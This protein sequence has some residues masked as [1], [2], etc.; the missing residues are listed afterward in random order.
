MKPNIRQAIPTYVINLEHRTDRKT[1]II[2]EFANREEFNIT[3]V[4]AI[5]HPIGAIGLWQTMCHII[6]KAKEGKV[7]FVLICEDDHHFTDNYSPE[8]LNVAIQ[9]AQKHL[10]D[11]LLGGISWFDIVLQVSPNLFWVN[12]FNATQF[13][14]VFDSCY[15]QIL[16]TRFDDGENADFK[17][18]SLTD[19]ILVMY[20]FISIQKEFG[21]SDVTLKNEERGWITNLFETKNGQLTQL[22]DVRKFY[23]Y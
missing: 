10:T 14:I 1:S 21:Y 11:V 22:V 4:S 2:N 15:D 17:I 12:T 23:E 20:P 8:N 16:Y 13:M 5:S 7:P 18:S 3:I 19:N 9:Y 6:T